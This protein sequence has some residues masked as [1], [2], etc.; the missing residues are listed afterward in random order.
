MSK[1]SRFQANSPSLVW[2]SSPSHPASDL[3]A[4]VKVLG[5][6]P[7]ALVM[8]GLAGA[9]FFLAL[10]SYGW[11]RDILDGRILVTFFLMSAQFAVTMGGWTYYQRDKWFRDK[12][13]PLEVCY[14]L[15]LDGD[16]E[17]GQP[18]ETPADFVTHKHNPKWTQRLKLPVE[19]GITEEKLEA[20]AKR[21]A[22]GN[23]AY[24]RREV[25]PVIG[26]ECYTPFSELLM[27]LGLLAPAPNKSYAWTRA[28]KAWCKQVGGNSEGS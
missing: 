14:Q 19:W 3:H 27:G 2:G 4:G 7:H 16:G 8:G 15:D 10:L 13:W 18:E 5:P 24:S 25:G 20:L 21:V 6:L 23:E 26:E 22:T 1:P 28:G 9:I 11:A 12:L 17:A